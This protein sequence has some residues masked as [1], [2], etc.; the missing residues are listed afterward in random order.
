MNTYTY[1]ELCELL[2]EE[3]KRSN[4][5][6]KQFEKWRRKYKIE[7]VENKNTYTIRPLT[8]QE[9]EVISKKCSYQQYIEP[10]LYKLLLKSKTKSVD[11]SMLDLMYDLYLVNGNYI[12][13]KYKANQTILCDYFNWDN[14]S[15]NDYTFETYKMFK[16]IIKDI[17][18]SMQ[19][20]DIITVS[21]V[22]MKVNKFSVD[23]VEKISV[24][25]MK[26]SEI[27]QLM[28]YR[29]IYTNEKY[30]CDKYKNLSY[31]KKQKVDE[32]VAKK[33]NM[34]WYYTNYHIILNKY[35]VKDVVKNNNYEFKDLGKLVNDN[36]QN[37]I[38]KSVQGDLKNI[39]RMQKLSITDTLINKQTKDGLC[40]RIIKGKM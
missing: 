21:E 27:A 26:D 14:K 19:S 3:Q 34:S 23:N 12:D 25:K 6:T 17:F 2:N 29:R 36:I 33:M 7:K 11:Y 37:K 5:R 1:K 28:K 13:A 30:Q 35:G 38:N 18:K 15:L 4:Q 20:R 8:L 39:V 9:K 10:M 40:K 32:F 24:E 31:Y 16:R 22:Y